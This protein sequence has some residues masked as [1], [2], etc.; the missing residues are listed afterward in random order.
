MQE[1][2]SNSAIDKN[3]QNEKD[4]NSTIDMWG[5][6]IIVITLV[7]MAVWFVS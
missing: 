5:A 7:V 6:L 4:D 1:Q 3:T 2:D